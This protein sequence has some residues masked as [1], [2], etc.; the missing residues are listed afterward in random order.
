MA[1][2][3][4]TSFDA[5]KAYL[6]EGSFEMVMPL[7][8]KHKVHLVVT[9]ERATKL[10]DYTNAHSNKNHRISVN[11]NL[12]RHA[13]LITLLHEMAHL[14]A[15]EQFGLKI[16]PHGRE[17]KNT[18]GQL[19]KVF[20]EA[21]IF[22]ADIA[23]ELHKILHNPPATTSGEEGLQRVLKQYDSHTSIFVA[24]EELQVGSLFIYRRKLYQKG[25]IV[26][27]RIRCTHTHSGKV[28]LFHPLCEVFPVPDVKNN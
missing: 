4:K 20:L 2:Y 14:L 11:G 3:E 10:G 27:K 24:V 6:P 9:R 19:L 28:Y 7:I 16:E 17:W 1:A 26:R 21:G 12:N 15:F 25:E 8:L 23:A 5:L 22:P 18:F 13:F